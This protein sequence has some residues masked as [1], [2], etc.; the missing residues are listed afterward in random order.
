MSAVAI[1][2]G[3]FGLLIGSFLN[4]LIYRVP[5]GRSVVSPPS[6]CPGCSAEIRPQDNIPVL[7][8]LLLR[9]RCRH[10]SMPISRRY[11]AV[12]LGTGLFFFAVSWLTLPA[13]FAAVSAP[14]TVAAILATIASLY[15]AA[16]TVALT[17]IDI[18][19]HRLP[20]AI[21]LPSY[22]VAIVLLGGASLLSGDGEAALRALAGMVALAAA[23]YLMALA[24]PGG[25][26]LG[27]VKLAGLLGLYLGYS[28]WSALAV[29]S[30]GAFILGGI[31]SI[32]LIAT[33]R[34]TRKSGIPFGP[35]MLAGAWVGLSAGQNIW[36]SYLGL[37]GLTAI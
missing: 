32:I 23:Y 17:L 20:N 16:V 35:W 30:F 26:G 6:S 28:S 5:L 21:V 19:V 4:V 25:M 11:P 10:C 7:S 3:V 29:G 12:E 36:A 14:A 2:L 37:F 8:W 22:I 24:Y 13:V 33:R 18:D 15:L 31:F 1:A 9:G 27:D 34:A